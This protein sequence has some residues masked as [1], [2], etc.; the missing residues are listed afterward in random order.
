MWLYYNNCIKKYAFVYKCLFLFKK[1]HMYFIMKAYVASFQNVQYIL[2][3]QLKP[4]LLA[5]SFHFIATS[6]G[7][8]PLT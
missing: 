1:L 6:S 4:A 3:T 5:L 8:S 7:N 2:D